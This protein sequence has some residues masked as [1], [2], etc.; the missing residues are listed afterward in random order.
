MSEQVISPRGR[1]D[2]KLKHGCNYAAKLLRRLGKRA[3]TPASEIWRHCSLAT[4]VRG[5]SV[6]RARSHHLCD[7]PTHC[8]Q[9][10]PRGTACPRANQAQPRRTELRA[11]LAPFAKPK[12][13]FA[14]PPARFKI[15]ILADAPSRFE[16]EKHGHS[17]AT[18]LCWCTTNFLHDVSETH[19]REKKHKKPGVLHSVR[20]DNSLPSKQRQ[21]EDK[22]QRGYGGVRCD[23]ICGAPKN[24]QPPH[25]GS[26]R[27]TKGV[28][29]SP[30]ERKRRRIY[31][32][33]D[34]RMR[35]HLMCFFTMPAILNMLH[36][37]ANFLYVDAGI[38]TKTPQ[39]LNAGTIRKIL[40][41]TIRNVNLPTRNNRRDAFDA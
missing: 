30:R 22:V 38:Y 7:V 23:G 8:P 27:D 24:R 10:K 31:R 39:N 1:N 3:E 40:H 5:W 26:L 33:F 14:M 32:A 13:C 12:R 18:S 28:D 34:P 41:T 17:L 37:I 35:S 11:Q 29:E 6:T 36:L 2:P 21:R 20:E 16:L 9:R 25:K 4:R 19:P 15:Q